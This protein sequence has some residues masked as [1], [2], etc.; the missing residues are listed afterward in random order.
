MNISAVYTNLAENKT[1]FQ[2]TTYLSYD[3]SLAVDGGLS[4]NAYD[5]SCTHTS[6]V[7]TR[8]WWAVDLG[9]FHPV[10]VVTILNRQDGVISRLPF[11]MK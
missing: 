9:K 1:A 8:P 5:N 11:L 10:A 3:A 6:N 4:T 2:Q 7:N